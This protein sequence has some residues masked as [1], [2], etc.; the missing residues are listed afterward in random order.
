MF[1]DID[2]MPFDSKTINYETVPGKIKHFYGFKYALGGIFSITAGDFE[3]TNGF[4]NVWDWGYED[5]I[6]QNRVNLKKI[7]IDYSQFFPFNDGNILQLKSDNNSLLTR[8]VQ[9]YNI[10]RTDGLNSIT[11]LNYVINEETGVVDVN[12]FHTISTQSISNTAAT[13]MYKNI[14]RSG[15]MF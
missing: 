7:P 14:K 5:I 11:E 4:P 3:K 9:Q 15:R 6:F 1:N 2:A 13:T 8:N 10:P 12:N